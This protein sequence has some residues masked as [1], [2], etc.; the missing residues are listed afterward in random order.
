MWRCCCRLE[1]LR[2]VYV[3]ASH[4]LDPDPYDFDFAIA[5]VAKNGLILSFVLNLD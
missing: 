4:G 2:P 1:L 3:M 5:L